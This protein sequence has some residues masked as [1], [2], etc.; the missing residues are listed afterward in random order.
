MSDQEKAKAL[1]LDAL[2]T[3]ASGSHDG[4]PCLVS[5]WTLVMETLDEDGQGWVTTASN[6][7]LSRWDRIGLLHYALDDIQSG[8]TVRDMKEEEA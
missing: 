8:M 3:L 6:D 2:T 7:A 1:I 4:A 5:K